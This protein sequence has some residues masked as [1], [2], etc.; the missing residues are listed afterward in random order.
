LTRAIAGAFISFALFGQTPGFEVASV[1]IAKP[2]AGRTG[3]AVSNGDR[4]SFTNTTVKNALARAFQVTGYQIDGPDWILTERYDIEARAPENTPK[5]QL[6]LMLQALLTDRFQLK[7]HREN[8]EMP[9]YELTAGKGEL[10]LEKGDEG[11]ATIEMSNGRKAKNTSM[12]QL[13]QFLAGMVQRPVF[14]KT[15]L[16]GAYNFA[17]PMS[18]EELG[19][20]SNPD[21]TAPSIFTIMEELGLKLESLKVPLEVI[22]VDG[23]NKVPTEN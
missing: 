16:Q 5:E 1:K 15:G 8:R 19:G 9:V 4:V 21:V 23:G 12:A 6:P 2:S 14:D 20:V 3:H 17:L 22:V 7:L 10:K 13:A 11:G 18:M